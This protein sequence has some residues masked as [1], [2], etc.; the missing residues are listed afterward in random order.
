MSERRRFARAPLTGGVILGLVIP[1][2]VASAATADPGPT[3]DYTLTVS[4]TETSTRITDDFQG[5]SVE[6]AD[7]AHG[8]LTRDRMAA[9]L[10]TLGPGVI[11][12]GGYSMDLVWP[13]FGA[14]AD[15]PPPPEAIGGVVE[16]S[17]LDHLDELV[18]ATGWKVTIGLPLK[19]IVD[20]SKV[21]N[22]TRDPAPATSIEQVVAEVRAAYDTLG[23]D[24]LGVEVGNEYD[25]VTTLTPAEMWQTMK[26]YR[27]AV[28]AAVPEAHL[29]VVGPSA[30]TARTNDKLDQLVTAALADD[31]TSV[32]GELSELA[33]HWY[34][35]SHCGSSTVTVDQ[36]VSDTAHLNTRAKLRGIVDISERLD[37]DSL[38]ITINESNSASCSGM[39]EVSNSYATSLWSLDYQL[40]AAKEGIDRLQ[41]HTNTAAVCGDFKPRDSQ[42]YPISY[43]YYGAFCAEDEAALA[44]G[45][46]SATPL[47]YGIWAFRQLPEGRF[48]DVDLPDADLS[49]LRAY[50]VKSQGGELTVVVINVQDPAD[51]TSTDASV[52]LNLP[53]SFDDARQVTLA[54]EDPVGLASLDARRITL[55]GRSVSAAGLPTGEPRSTTVEVDDRTSTLIVEP[56][57]AQIV[58]YSH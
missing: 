29:K 16:Q 39:P 6:S 3:Q 28:R 53:S 48:L 21:K 50:A 9:R 33:S 51:P 37:A 2:A 52:T 15:A 35:W 13:A 25:N 14:W 43:R 41:F 45:D 44:A 56:G 17:D 58:T 40:Q 32:N 46:L 4:D 23:D 10:S 11:R 47:Y 8:F 49:A 5:F 34:P 38:P 27:T 12:I 42:D 55:G 31:S 1:A 7:F 22:P 19:S 26:D 54:S 30:N 24:L 36:I 18:D 20:P 57:S